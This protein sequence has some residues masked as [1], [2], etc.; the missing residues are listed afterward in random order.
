MRIYYESRL[1]K[2]GLA[3]DSC[4]LIATDNLATGSLNSDHRR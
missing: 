3:A 4:T 2:I 1:A